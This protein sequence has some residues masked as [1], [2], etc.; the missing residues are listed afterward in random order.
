METPQQRSE[1]QQTFFPPCPIQPWPHSTEFGGP[2]YK[3]HENVTGAQQTPA[4]LFQTYYR[5]GNGQTTGNEPPG[6][7]PGAQSTRTAK[8]IHQPKPAGWR[9]VTLKEI[10]P[11]TQID[12]AGMGARAGFI[13]D[14]IG[15]GPV[16]VGQ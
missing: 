13:Y 5:T 6:G 9:I 7:Q 16:R 10:L 4:P 12:K 2:F 11:P 15:N 8:H 1:S 14:C 3:F